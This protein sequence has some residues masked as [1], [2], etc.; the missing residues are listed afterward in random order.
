VTIAGKTYKPRQDAHGRWH[1]VLTT[2]ETRGEGGLFLCSPTPGYE[3]V[4]GDLA[5]LPVFSAVKR[6]AL[7]EAA[8]SLNQYWPQPAGGSGSGTDA[9]GRPGDDF[10][11]RGDIRSILARHGWTLARNAGHDG[12]EH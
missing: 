5:E 1:V 10:N 9:N 11:Q 4:Q 7:L 3:M 12:N 6:E 2:I 8:W